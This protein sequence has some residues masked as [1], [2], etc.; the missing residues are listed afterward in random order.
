M[1]SLYPRTYPSV[2][3]MLTGI[4]HDFEDARIDYL[5]QSYRDSKFLKLLHEEG[6]HIGIY[7]DDYY[8]YNN[9]DAMEEYVGNKSENTA[10]RRVV[11]KMRL[12]WDMV[13]LSLYRYLPFSLK[14]T[15]GDISTPDFQK[16]VEYSTKFPKYNSDMKKGYEYLKENQIVLSESEKNFSFIHLAGC[17]LPNDYN[18]HFRPATGEDLYDTVVSL[19]QSFKIIDQYLVALKEAGLYEDATIII[20]GDHGS[21]RGSDTTLLNAE[22]KD[23]PFLTALLVKPSGSANEPLKISSAPIA[24]GDVIPTI[25]QSEGI[26]TEVDFG[27]SIFDVKEGE[28]RERRT[29]FHS[30]QYNPDGSVNYE[31]V[32][33]RIVGSGRT[34]ENWSIV[35]RGKF[36]GDIYQ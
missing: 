6:Y 8:G 17:H 14:G 31:E 4:E 32:L 24:Q 34:L 16:Y 5:N 28:Q 7:T 36:I 21:L 10:T 27:R 20:S 19:T 1:I 29:V 9:A 13:R 22:E 33:F 11:Q 23:A 18:E 3:Y 30:L 2:P 26:E 12:S 35:S 25:L 15:V